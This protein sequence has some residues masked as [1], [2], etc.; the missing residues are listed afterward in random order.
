MQ[1]TSGA[2]LQDLYLSSTLDGAS[3]GAYL[4]QLQKREMPRLEC[5]DSKAITREIPTLL[6]MLVTLPLSSR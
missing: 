2:G 5:P 1:E 3:A 6:A 4:A